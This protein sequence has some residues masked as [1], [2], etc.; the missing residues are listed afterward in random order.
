[1]TWISKYGAA[2]IALALSLIA[3]AAQAQQCVI[4]KGEDYR[5]DRFGFRDGQAILRFNSFNDRVSSVK[6]ANGCRLV[7]FEGYDGRGRRLAIERNVKRLAGDW[8]NTI[9]GAISARSP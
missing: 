9:S 8:D 5:G 7:A 6:V 4:Y 3:G 1:M 2:A